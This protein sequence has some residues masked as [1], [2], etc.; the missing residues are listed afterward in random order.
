MP[1]AHR[2]R[3]LGSQA[4]AEG[5]KALKDNILVIHPWDNVA[6]EQALKAYVTQKASNRMWLWRMP[7]VYINERL[8]PR[9][10]SGPDQ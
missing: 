8:I 6:V 3:A 7:V 4:N 9:R 2:R 10:C 5:G 1:E